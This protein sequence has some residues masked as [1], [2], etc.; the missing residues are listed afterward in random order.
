M[1]FLVL[2]TDRHKL[3]GPML[4]LGKRRGSKTKLHTR[5]RKFATKTEARSWLKELGPR[6]RRY[7]YS[8]E[9]E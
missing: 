1:G 5:A 9:P 7:R 3:G 6:D 2:L 4:A 8:I